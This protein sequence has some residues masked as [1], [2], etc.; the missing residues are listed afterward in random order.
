MP[1]MANPASGFTVATVMRRNSDWLFFQT[2]QFLRVFFFHQT[3]PFDFAEY[4]TIP[5]KVF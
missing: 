5:I 3:T 1:A 4:F 2:D